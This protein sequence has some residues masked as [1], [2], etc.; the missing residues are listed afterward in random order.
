MSPSREVPV[1]SNSSAGEDL[2]DGLDGQPLVLKTRDEAQAL[3]M[4]LGVD[5]LSTSPMESRL[6][7][8]LRRHPAGPHTGSTEAGL[9]R[10]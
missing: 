8:S 4:L 1:S 2:A 5:G 6:T 9:I 10:S 7:H 3:G